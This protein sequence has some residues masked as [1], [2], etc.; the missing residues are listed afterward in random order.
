M[1]WD[2]AQ[3]KSFVKQTR[4]EVGDGWNWM[5]PR[6]RESMI[7][8]RAFAVVRGQVMETVRVEDI[9]KLYRDMMK[10]AGLGE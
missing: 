2:K 10:E 9:C 8:D 7:A 5:V 6:I 1:S 4:E 3:V